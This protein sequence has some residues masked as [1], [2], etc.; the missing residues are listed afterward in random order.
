MLE[1]IEDQGGI[2][3]IESRNLEKSSRLYD[4][5]DNSKL[6][7]GLADR[8][9]RS[10]MNITFGL[11]SDELTKR[12]VEEAESQGLSSLKGH[13]SLGG[14]RASLYNAMPMEGVQRLV[15]FMDIFE[16]THARS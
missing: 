14:L 7:T 13:R 16:K 9:D 2:A 3:E 4:F 5:I 12:F 15:E 10:L 1:W 11:P 8:H 6:Y